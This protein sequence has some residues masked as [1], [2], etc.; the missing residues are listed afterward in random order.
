MKA[1]LFFFSFLFLIIKLVNCQ[2]NSEC[3][4]ESPLTISDC[5]SHSTSSNSCCFYR[6]DGARKC[7]WWDSKTVTTIYVDSSLQYQCDNYKSVPCE[8]PIAD[9]PETCDQSSFVTNSCCYFVDTNNIGRCMWWGEGFRGTTEY[10]GSEVI[11]STVCN[12][13][14][15]FLVLAY[16]LF[17]II[18]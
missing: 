13:V 6:Q 12:V 17:I 15:L 7:K 10:N 11:C 2:T 14:N 18:N 16:C 3:E 4:S 8:P 9:S 5:A 1:L